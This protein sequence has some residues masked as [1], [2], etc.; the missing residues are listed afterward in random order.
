MTIPE[1]KVQAGATILSA[2]LTGKLLGTDRSLQDYE[3]ATINAVEHLCRSFG[4]VDPER[5]IIDS[6]L[7]D[8][9]EEQLRD[10]ALA[11]IPK[12]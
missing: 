10:E 11:S 3:N 1:Q 5:A 8:L 4:L 6:R 9:T 2:M 7:P 12:D